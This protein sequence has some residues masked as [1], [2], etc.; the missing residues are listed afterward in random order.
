MANRCNRQSPTVAVTR[1]HTHLAAPPTQSEFEANLIV[2]TFSFKF[3]NSYAACIYVAFFRQT[4]PRLYNMSHQDTCPNSY[5][6]TIEE[7]CDCFWDLTVQLICQFF[8]RDVLDR[9]FAFYAPAIKVKLAG[10]THGI[11]NKRKAAT[12]KVRPSPRSPLM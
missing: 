5:I 12:G 8:A 1:R 2:K 6:Y 11:S 3:I 10:L 4:K 9:I 7:P